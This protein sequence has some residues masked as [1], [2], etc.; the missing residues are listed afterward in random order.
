MAQDTAGFYAGEDEISGRPR[1]VHTG[2]IIVTPVGVWYTVNDGEPERWLPG[3]ESLMSIMAAAAFELP[4]KFSVKLRRVCPSCGDFYKFDR[5]C[6][7]FDNGG[8]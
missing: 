1:F 5:S 7:C 4:A 3:I 8:E 2:A 6:D